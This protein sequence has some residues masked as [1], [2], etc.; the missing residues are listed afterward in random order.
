MQ[1]EQPHAL[2][3]GVM[4]LAIGLA[5]YAQVVV[6]RAPDNLNAWLFLAI[7]AVLAASAAADRVRIRSSVTITAVSPPRSGAA[8]R[9]ALVTLAVVAIAA[10][11]VLS[12]I[13]QQ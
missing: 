1:V 7:A 10:T 3:Q 9:I 13:R 5:L 6:H 2:R 12:T 4:A 8:V 11:T